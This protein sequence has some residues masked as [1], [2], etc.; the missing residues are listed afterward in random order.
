[1]RLET[2][3][4]LLVLDCRLVEAALVGGG[5]GATFVPD[6]PPTEEGLTIG[7]GLVG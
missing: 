3:S 5:G 1:M 4:I 6:M 2:A 7:W